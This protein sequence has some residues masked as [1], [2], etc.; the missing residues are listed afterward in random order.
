MKI[1]LSKF[2][3]KLFDKHRDHDTVYTF[4]KEA[5]EVYRNFSHEIVT[6][7]NKQLQEDIMV[8]DMC[9]DGKIFIR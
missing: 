4:S 1:V 7:M 5:S 9:K 6:K 8:Q 2:I 3:K